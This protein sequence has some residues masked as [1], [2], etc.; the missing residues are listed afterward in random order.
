MQAGQNRTGRQTVEKSHPADMCGW[1]G[2]IQ[3]N[4]PLRVCKPL[5]GECAVRRQ[6][7]S[8]GAAAA[9]RIQWMKQRAAA[10]AAL[11][12]SQALARRENRLSARGLGGRNF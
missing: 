9:K 3:G 1:M 2:H 8:P 10:G 7:L 6:I 11:R 12:F 4:L 5:C